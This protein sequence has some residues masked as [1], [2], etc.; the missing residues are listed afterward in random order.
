MCGGRD[1]AI[2][3]IGIQGGKIRHL[4]FTYSSSV[5]GVADHHPL[6]EDDAAHDVGSQ[7]FP[8]S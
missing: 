8:R 6:P 4:I 3:S 1:R 5:Y 2:A 7:D